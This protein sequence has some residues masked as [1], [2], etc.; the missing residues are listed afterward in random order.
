[1]RDRLFKGS[2]AELADIPQADNYIVERYSYPGK[3]RWAPR[4]A[5]TVAAR[6]RRKLG[7]EGGHVL[8]SDPP[9]G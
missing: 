3:W 5:A 8:Q 2:G 6:I 9:V 7:D 1:V 4:F